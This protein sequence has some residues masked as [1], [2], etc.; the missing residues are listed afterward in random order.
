MLDAPVPSTHFIKTVKTRRVGW[1]GHVEHMTA[2][3]LRNLKG[4][5]PLGRI[6]HRWK[7]YI[8]I[9]VEGTG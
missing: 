3:L 7:D 4:K 1:V 6:R 5:R 8:K 9:D 2:K